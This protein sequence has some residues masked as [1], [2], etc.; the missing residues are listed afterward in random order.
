M[1]AGISWGRYCASVAKRTLRVRDLTAALSAVAPPA[2]AAAWDNVGL[3]AGD[4]SAPCERVLLTIDLTRDVLE[5]ARDLRVQAVVAYHPPLFE[6]LKRFVSGTHPSGVVHDAIRSGVALLSPHTALDAVQGGVNDWIADGIGDGTR[7]P[8]EPSASLPATEAFVIVTHAPQDAVERIRGAMSIAGAG[9]IGDYSQ[10]SVATAVE[11]TFFGGSSTQPRTGRR[12]SLERVREI[13]FEMVC[14]RRA[15]PS[16]L[17]A[18]RQ[19]HPYETPP[20]QVHALSPHLSAR[21]GQGRLIELAQPASASE[22]ARRLKRHLGTTRIECAAAPDASVEH[23]V[24]GLC[25]GAGM[26]LCEAAIEAGATLFMT[27]EAR[28]HEQ[29]A[30]TARGCTLLLAGHT[31]TER[32]YLPRLGE[33][34]ARAAPRMQFTISQRDRHPLE[35]L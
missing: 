18:L 7:R 30:A 27:G 9:R 31:I 35:A 34:L 17:A 11:G 2:L 22:I 25:A 5:E 21:Q 15:L 6:P 4:P 20:V 33:R 10:C 32:G 3:L 13:R 16:A 1:S 12:G 8:L 26:S 29:L 14:G 28:H 23:T 19:A 24:I